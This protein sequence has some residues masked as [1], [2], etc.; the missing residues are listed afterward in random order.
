MSLDYSVYIGPVILCSEPVLTESKTD[1]HGCINK[2]CKCFETE[3]KAPFCAQCG[4]KNGTFTVTED[5]EDFDLYELSHDGLAEANPEYRRDDDSR[6]FIANRSFLKRETHLDAHE[7]VAM[8]LSKV[9]RQA[10]IQEL[11]KFAEEWLP[12]IRKAFKKV[13]LT[14]GLYMWTS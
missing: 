10:E 13:E 11:A 2:K 7:T 6:I 8:D 9:D 5:M 1:L 12:G 4:S 3:S 14:W